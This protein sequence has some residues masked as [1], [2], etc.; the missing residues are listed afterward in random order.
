MRGHEPQLVSTKLVQAL[1]F[2]AQ[3]GRGCT[4][5][6]LQPAQQTPIHQFK[7]FSFHGL[8]GACIIVQLTQAHI[9]LFLLRLQATGTLLVGAAVVAIISDPMVEAVRAPKPVVVGPTDRKPSIL[10]FS[11]TCFT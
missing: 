6:C 8:N 5:S 11:H 3:K 9:P 7:A 2:R 4:T 10:Q 1:W